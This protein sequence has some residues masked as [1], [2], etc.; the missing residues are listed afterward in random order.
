MA[1]AASSRAL[2]RTIPL[3][4]MPDRMPRAMGRVRR[5]KGGAGSER[6]KKTNARRATPI[7]ADENKMLIR[8]HRRPINVVSQLL[9]PAFRVKDTDLPCR[10]QGAQAAGP[11]RGAQLAQ[12]FG[13]YLA[14]AFAR[15]VEFLA[16]LFQRVL[17]LAADAEAHAN[18]LLLFRGE[19]LEDAGR[20]IAHIGFNY[21]IDGRAHPAV[22]DE[23]AQGRFAVAAHRG[24]QRYRIARDGLQLLDLL[25]RDVHPAEKVFSFWTFSTGM[26]IRRPIS[27]FVGVR[28]SSFSSSRVARRNLFMLSFMCT[29]MRMVRDWSA[30]ARV[31]ACRIHHVA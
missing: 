13:F 17:A 9:S 16:D 14:N 7:T 15:D 10:H 27:S 23:I 19:R 25:H 2:P 20:L 3:R 8:V 24:F 26:S 30:M 28:P 6:Q 22:F 18:Y 5:K 31:M 21:G 4:C 11:L 29:G 12:R 1:L